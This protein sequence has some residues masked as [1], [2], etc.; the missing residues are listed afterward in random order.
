MRPG[1]GRGGLGLRATRRAPRLHCRQR[2]LRKPRGEAEARRRGGSGSGARRGGGSAQSSPGQRRPVSARGRPRGR[3]VGGRPGR[4]GRRSG[5][6]CGAAGQGRPPR[7][8][9]VSPPLL[10][11]L[12]PLCLWLSVFPKNNSQPTPC[13][14]PRC[15][16]IVAGDSQDVR[17]LANLP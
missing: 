8:R 17:S 9:S 2:L 4:R 11:V 1:A 6:V 14:Q 5:R 12:S 7:R 15:L 10:A 13:P 3:G 16:Y